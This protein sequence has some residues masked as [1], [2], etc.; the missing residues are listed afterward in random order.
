MTIPDIFKKALWIWFLLFIGLNAVNWQDGGLN[1]ASRF[2]AIQAMAE[3]HSFRINPYQ[4]WTEDWSQTPDGSIYSNKAPGPM[5]MAVPV[6]WL[7]NRAKVLIYGDQAWK[8]SPDGSR[9]L[10]EPS[11]GYMTLI[12]WIF[13]IIRSVLWF[14]LPKNGF[15]SAVLLMRPST[16]R[17]LRSC[18]E[19]R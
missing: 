10:S 7:L 19:T 5:L 1:T 16:S 12:S 18:S 11:L 14:I 13:Q 2:A 17:S 6:A 3:D 4:T 9:R 15:E 8:I